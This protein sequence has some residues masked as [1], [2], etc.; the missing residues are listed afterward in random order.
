MK[1]VYKI[2]VVILECPRRNWEH[3]FKMDLQGIRCEEE[4]LTNLA[5]DRDQWRAFVN[6]VKNLRVP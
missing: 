4:D 1:T 3:N 2:L 5:S 6:T